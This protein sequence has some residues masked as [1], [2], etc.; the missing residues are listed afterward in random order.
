[1]LLYYTVPINIYI[2]YEV[3]IYMYQVY[4]YICIYERSIIA[5]LDVKPTN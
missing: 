1:M 3:Y 2:L 4:I 5:A